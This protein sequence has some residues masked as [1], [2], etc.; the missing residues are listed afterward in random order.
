MQSEK[1]KKIKSFTKKAK[2]LRAKGY[3]LSQIGR[4]LGK[5]HTTVM[6]HIGKTGII[7]LRRKKSDYIRKHIPVNEK[8]RN[9]KDMVQIILPRGENKERK[10]I[11]IQDQ[12]KKGH[13]LWG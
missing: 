7:K 12:I 11:S 4:M 5:D 1:Q 3:S 9:Y 10:E 8:G 13:T 2:K 6:Y